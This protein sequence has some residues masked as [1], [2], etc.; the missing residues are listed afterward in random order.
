MIAQITGQLENIDTGALLIKLEAGLTYQVLVSPYTSARLGNSIGQVVNL[1][2]LHYLESQG[3]GSTMIPRLAGFISQ[4]DKQFYELFTTC[5]GIGNRKALRAM[6]LS[7]T[8]LAR[9][10]AD[11]DAAMLTSLPEIGKRT[12]E[13]I[14]ATLHGKVDHFL[15][16]SHFTNAPEP[17][18]EATSDNTTQAIPTSMARQALE[19]L[20]TLGENRTQAAQW[21][22]Q[23]LHSD[24]KP[25][26]VQELINQVYLV[27]T[28]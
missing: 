8:Q 6:S 19:I 17:G 11:R 4:I 13:T 1:Y 26:D 20:V 7:V 18:A 12:A 10:I 14:I 21:I 3:Q 15:D 16:V 2:T 23:V 27:R 25:K 9:A 22:D 5:K 24:D 28:G